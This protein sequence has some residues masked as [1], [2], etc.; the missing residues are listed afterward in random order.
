DQTNPIAA[1]YAGG[2]N[3]FIQREFQFTT[4]IEADLKGLLQGLTF[5]T[6]LGVDYLNRYNQG[7]RNGY[8]TYQPN[9]TTYAGSTMVG[10]LTRWGEDTKTG[11]Q[12]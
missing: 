8:A 10:S 11:F 12:N 3:R 5:S 1:I 2:N 7:Y 9:L 4:G 6:N